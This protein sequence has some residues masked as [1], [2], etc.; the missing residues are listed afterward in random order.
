MTRRILGLGLA[1]A[2]ALALGGGLALAQNVPEQFVVSGQAAETIQ[3][4][5]TINLAT[6]ERLA[7]LCEKAGSDE[8]CAVEG[9]KAT[10]GDH[11]TLP[12][13]PAAGAGGR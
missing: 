3:D 13:Y 6:A 1:A 7:E 4:F 9:L 10:F 11:V 5:T 12:V 2:G 8:N